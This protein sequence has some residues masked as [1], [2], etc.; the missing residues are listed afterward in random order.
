MKPIDVIGMG[1]SKKDLT[2]RHLE[3]I[4]RCDILIAGK[5]LLAMFDL[6]GVEKIRVTGAIEN[7][8][9]IIKKKMDISKIVVLASGDPLYYGIGSTLINYFPKEQ[10]TVYSNIS[11]VSAAFA[12]IK[13]PWHD[14]KIITLHGKQSKPFCFSTLEGE[15]KVAFLTD[16]KNNPQ[17]IAD[18]L[19]KNRLLNFK[20]CV[21]ENLGDE[22]KEKIKWMKNIEEAATQKFSHPNIVIL[23]KDRAAYNK[24]ISHETHIGMEDS[25]FKHSKGLITKSEIRSIT[26]SKL[27]LIKKNHRLWDVGSGSGSLA[28]EAALQIPEG[29]VYA[30][31]KNQ[32]RICDIVYNSRKF[33]C[34]NIKVLHNTFLEG[35]DDIEK[36]PDRIFI[37]G[38]GKGLQKILHSC[39]K[40]LLPSGVIV[41]NSVVLQNFQT[42][43]NLLE[44][45]KFNPQIVQ[46]Q[47]SRSR[48]M[49]SGDRLEALNPVWIIS[50]TKPGKANNIE[51]SVWNATL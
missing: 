44:R 38:G 28:I 3:I 2:Q 22:K 1:H 30:I 20:F 4:N 18:E 35:V 15:D 46:I 8:V 19:I 21:V 14:A 7:I 6:P 10:I 37:G 26:L 47:I 50:G 24:N 40:K 36:R 51:P 32:N 5:R 11:S 48:S 17:Y 42:A 34:A 49:P 39:C 45:L 31:E 9:E 12:A 25:E 13:E 41:I 43:L 29:E 23:K 16:P 33:N 27:K